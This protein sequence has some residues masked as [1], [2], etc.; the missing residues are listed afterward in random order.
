MVTLPSSAGE[1]RHLIPDLVKS[2]MSI[3]RINCS[4]D[5]P[6]EW[7]KMVEKVHKT[8]KSSGKI[9]KI[10][11]DLG[12]PKLRTGPLEPGP[13]IVRLRPKRD[14][15]GRIVAE[16]LVWLAPENHPTT[17]NREYVHLPVE[18]DFLK[19]LDDTSI[20]E[21]HD[22]RE[23]HC[24]L[25]VHRTEAN[26]AWARCNKS[27]YVEAGTRLSVLEEDDEHSTEV[28]ELPRLPHAIVLKEGDTLE[29]TRQSS[30]GSP[31]QYGEPDEI[32]RPA[33]ISCQVPEV[34]EDLKPGESIMLDDGKLKGVI[35]EVSGDRIS[36]QVSYAL[37]GALKLKADK[38]INL[39]DSN[40]SLSGLTRKDR[41]DLRFAAE[42]ADIVSLS[43][44]NSASDVGELCAALDEIGAAEL[45]IVL[46]V[47][48][49]K[50][51]KQLP[52]ILLAGMSRY[53]MGVMIARGDLAIEA[54]W[55]NLA[56][57][58][59][60]ILW[61][62]EAAH[63]P[64]IWATQVLENLAKNGQ[65]SRAEISDVSIAERAECVMLNKGPHIVET[66]GTL[67]E[68][69]Q[70]MEEYQDKKAPL[71]P[72]WHT[73]EDPGIKVKRKSKKKDPGTP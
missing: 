62:C 52:D 27:A 56:R 48:T 38:G 72:I 28:G 66:V 73:E 2:G 37:G 25:R 46:K 43:F 42:H 3:A 35:K 10:A 31:A 59:E 53:P 55:Q 17:P 6:E 71:L 19:H 50:G 5:T 45:G 58:Q 39:P 47:E 69:L 18:A 49:M 68:I 65:P 26:G 14:L 20:I 30:P 61:M 40:L 7:S 70:S 24:Q 23:K 11:M 29:I 57:I 34:F 22:T 1:D 21:F 67:S 36:V 15:M 12:G 64:I 4:H 32:I 9:V 41:E 44:V 51:F 8:R 13:R 16:P 60:E 63:A 33:R 54:G